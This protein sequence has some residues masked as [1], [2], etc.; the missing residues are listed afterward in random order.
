MRVRVWI[1]VPR[2]RTRPKPP[3]TSLGR[4]HGHAPR[5]RVA[6]SLLDGVRYRW[7]APSRPVPNRLHRLPGAGPGHHRQKVGFLDHDPLSIALARSC[8]DGD[9]VGVRRFQSEPGPVTSCP[10]GLGRGGVRHA[11]EDHLRRRLRKPDRRL[12]SLALRVGRSS[13]TRRRS[14]D[15]GGCAKPVKAPR[16]RLPRAP[17][18]RTGFRGAE[19]GARSASPMPLEA[20]V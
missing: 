11:R 1:L 3:G 18:A 14:D 7:W 13:T 12:R 15:D 9:G 19:Q 10:D 5:H 20:A 2:V 6:A 16:T 8:R 4:S 17:A